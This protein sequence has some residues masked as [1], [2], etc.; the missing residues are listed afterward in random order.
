MDL[1][2][3]NKRSVILFGTLIVAL[4]F[5]ISFLIGTICSVLATDLYLKK[6]IDTGRVNLMIFNIG[7][8]E[9]HLHHWVM[10]VLVFLGIYL[11]GVFPDLSYF[12]IGVG[13]GVIIHDLYTDDIWYK[14][15]Y[16]NHEEE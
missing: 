9:I 11:V 15:V 16:R 13:L 3:S 14:V 6:F 12:W 7:K 2:N 1:I 8:W 10:G 4:F 5:P